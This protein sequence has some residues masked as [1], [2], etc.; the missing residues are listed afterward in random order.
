MG[1]MFEP[2]NLNGFGYGHQ[3]P[4][5]LVDP[6]GNLPW[7]SFLVK[8]FDNGTS[9]VG[10]G[11]S[12]REAV[13]AR[14]KGYSTWSRSKQAARQSGEAAFGKENLLR[15]RGHILKSGKKGYP[16][17]QTEGRFGH[18]SWGKM[19]GA[20]IGGVAFGS[21]IGPFD[22]SAEALAL[23]PRMIVGENSCYIG[24]DLPSDISL[25]SEP[26]RALLEEQEE[27]SM[28]EEIFTDPVTYMPPVVDTIY[29][30][31]RGTPAY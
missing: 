2:Q 31:L 7:K 16:H 27:P 1:G 12:K 24:Y 3:N 28:F 4:L 8:L 20:V 10:R 17:Y 6:D 30:F 18:S 22:A 25:H 5:V 29:D 15:H 23:E 9:K 14:R 26:P 19:G 21:M 13:L 11:L